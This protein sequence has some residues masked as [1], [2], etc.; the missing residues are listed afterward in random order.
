METVDVT[1]KLPKCL[2]DFLNAHVENLEEWLVDE[3]VNHVHGQLE[4]EVFFNP[5]EAVK[6]YNLMPLFNAHEITV[7]SVIDPDRE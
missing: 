7:S 5:K 2:A 4:A 1:L 3:I 6:K